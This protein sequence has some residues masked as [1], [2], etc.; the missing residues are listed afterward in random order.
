MALVG[1]PAQTKNGWLKT[2]S[3]SDRSNESSH[4]SLAQFRTP[5]A[6]EPIGISLKKLVAAMMA[7]AAS[8][9]SLPS[10]PDIALGNAVALPSDIDLGNARALPSTAD[11]TALQEALDFAQ[12]G[13]LQRKVNNWKALTKDQTQMDNIQR[14]IHALA[15]V[16]NQVLPP[17]SKTPN[18]GTLVDQTRAMQATIRDALIGVVATILSTY[19][20]MIQYEAGLANLAH[21]QQETA[22]L[23]ENVRNQISAMIWAMDPS[24]GT[25]EDKMTRIAPIVQRVWKSV[26]DGFTLANDLTVDADTLLNKTYQ[27]IEVYFQTEA[28]SV[29]Q[30]FIEYEI[31]INY[32][33]L[34]EKFVD[35]VHDKVADLNQ[36]DGTLGEN[37]ALGHDVKEADRSVQDRRKVI[38]KELN[39]SITQMPQ[40]DVR[41]QNMEAINVCA[42]LDDKYSTNLLEA[43]TAIT[44]NHK[45]RALSEY[46]KDFAT[47]VTKARL[48]V[49]HKNAQGPKPGQGPW[50]E[51]GL[52][53]ATGAAGAAG[54]GSLCVL[55]L[56]M[57]GTR[58]LRRSREGKS[59]TKVEVHVVTDQDNGM[60]TGRGR[61]R[62]KSPEP[63]HSPSAS[64]GILY[65]GDGGPTGFTMF[66]RMLYGK[67]D[68]VVAYKER[69]HWV[70]VDPD[71]FTSL[72]TYY[73]AAWK[74]LQKSRLFQ[75]EE[76]FNND[77]TRF[78]QYSA[79]HK[80][81]QAKL[82]KD[83]DV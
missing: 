60:K 52:G 48:G 18:D 38:V 69:D 28:T 74:R 40:S 63:T 61:G 14:E 31:I 20:P 81:L 15:E 27:A 44:N 7:A 10:S 26:E 19:D 65:A 43:F 1:P 39:L 51:F 13:E 78:T 3:P 57:V 62:S 59:E 70:R 30:R 5:D 21:P 25:A 2:V 12:R 6:L 41:S 72:K 32:R 79:A 55:G 46:L 71:T 66:Y 42:L 83:E 82:P 58:W 34:N 29:H 76:R 35:S 23:P 54:I 11:N 17:V 4:H 53:L 68:P 49:Q 56:A 75:D 64:N 47:S 8:A 9:T 37:F 50:Y 73:Q 33:L 36:M 24:G 67:P 22:K 80:L 16:Y 77:H 45:G